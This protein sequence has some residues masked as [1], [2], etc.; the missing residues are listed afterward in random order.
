VETGTGR[1]LT[2]ARGTLLRVR[3][4]SKLAAGALV[5]TAVGIG[6]VSLQLAGRPVSASLTRGIALAA[7]PVA[8]AMAIRTASAIWRGPALMHF[9]VEYAVLCRASEA[10]DVRAAACLRGP[11]GGAGHVHRGRLVVPVVGWLLAA[12]VLGFVAAG[13]AER[14]ECRQALVW[15]GVAVAA[16]ALFPARPFW[17]RERRDGS[18]VLYPASVTAH[19]SLRARRLSKAA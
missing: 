6:A 5:V 12:V 10:A 14:P 15:M 16:R 8:I 19:V 18:V 7:L 3:R 9:P 1:A 17:Y 4:S 2:P 11:L 13:A